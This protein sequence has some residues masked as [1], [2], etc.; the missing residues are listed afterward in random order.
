MK[1]KFIWFIA[2]IVILAGLGTGIYFYL[3]RLEDTSF[4]TNEQQWLEE[5]RNY[6][7]PF[8][9]PSDIAGLTNMG[10]GVFFDFLDYL[11]DRTGLTIN[12]VAYKYGSDIQDAEY[13][14]E[15]VSAVSSNQLE[16]LTDHFVIITR[17][18]VTYT[19]ANGLAGKRIGVLERYEEDAKKYLVGSNIELVVFESEQELNRSLAGTD[20]YAESVEGIIALRSVYLGSLLTENIYISYHITDMIRY[21]VIT[22]NGN[23]ILNTIIEKTYTLWSRNRL[24]ATYNSHLLA[25]YFSLRNVSERDQTTLWDKSYIYGSISNGIFD[26]TRSGRPNGTNH[27]IINS[28]A[29]FANIDITYNNNYSSIG[30]LVN[31]FNSGEIDFLFGNNDGEYIVDYVT[32]AASIRGEI[33]I[34]SNNRNA[35]LVRTL[36]SL[37]GQ[38]V[39]VVEG[40]KIEAYLEEFGISTETHIDLKTMLNRVNN[41][42]IMAMDLMNYEF[43]KTSE[44]ANFKINYIFNLDEPYHFVVNANNQ[45]FAE[46]FDFYLGYVSVENLI[47]ASYAQVYVVDNTIIY[48]YV[49]IV[50]MSIVIVIQFVYYINR[51]IVYIKKKRGSGFTLSK[52]E[53]I[54]YVDTLTSLKNRNYFSDN[55]EK[56]D[57]SE[58]YPQAVVVIDLNNIAYINDNFGHEEGDKVIAEAASILIKTQMSKTEIMRTDG[59]EFLVYMV[60]YDEKQVS[61]YVKKLNKEFKEL[62]HEFGAAIG[63]STI[64]DAI[65]TIDDA[66]N[67]ALLDMRANKESMLEE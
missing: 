60:E 56:W 33:A 59:N 25:S 3:N 36:N 6:V 44:L 11:S 38:T 55:I 22:L 19:T 63:Y 42:S 17:E 16:V 30:N 64:A 46:L 51:L 57:N 61:S 4:S 2:V 27:Y 34:L 29:N 40:T 54:K 13:A 18:N 41:N 49:I 32:T 53:K 58:V 65:K 5:N 35:T 23:P 62:S 14:V 1:R 15:I 45:V 43:H 31:A 67:E 7:V 39:H 20:E 26:F 28:F 52:G 50:L 9:M 66:V 12:P 48:L 8:R 21:Y 10:E 37:Y 24:E 47:A